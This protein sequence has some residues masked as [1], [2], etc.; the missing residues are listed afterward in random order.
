[1][2][3]TQCQYYCNNCTCQSYCCES[4]LNMTDY[5]SAELTATCA[6]L[7][8]YDGSKYYLDK[9]CLGKITYVVFYSLDYLKNK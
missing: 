7:G 2:F 3:Y 5:L 9:N 6:V 8:Y 4:S 1:M